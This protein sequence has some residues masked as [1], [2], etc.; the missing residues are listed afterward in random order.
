MSNLDFH[1]KPLAELR[2]SYWMIQKLGVGGFGKVYLIRH[3]ESREFRAAKHQKWTNSDVPKLI[4][5]EVLVLR[6]LVYKVSTN[7]IVFGLFVFLLL[8]V[9]EL[10]LFWLP[11]LGIQIRNMK[12]VFN[13]CGTWHRVMFEKLRMKIYDFFLFG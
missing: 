10:C 12:M 2:N 5:R 7:E 11:I 3:R 13:I 6:K 4:R 9:S 8:V 1:S